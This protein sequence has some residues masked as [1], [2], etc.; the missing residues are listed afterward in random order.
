MTIE[1]RKLALL[2]SGYWFEYVRI[3]G[4]SWCPTENG[5]SKLSRMLDV[6]KKHIR[7]AINLYLEA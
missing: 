2:G 1:E 3:N 5:L 7:K 4:Y 6:N